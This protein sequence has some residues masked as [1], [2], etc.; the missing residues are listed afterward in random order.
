ME[1]FALAMAACASEV[2]SRLP[3]ASK[4]LRRESSP[5]SEHVRSLESSL[6]FPTPS[7]ARPDTLV[8][9]KPANACLSQGRRLPAALVSGRLSSLAS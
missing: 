3:I 4:Q 5:L 6:V 8:L 1:A 7:H 2:P 9:A